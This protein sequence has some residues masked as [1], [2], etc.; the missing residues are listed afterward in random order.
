MSEKDV[1]GLQRAGKLE[2]F[3][4]SFLTIVILLSPLIV[5]PLGLSAVLFA[6][7]MHVILLSAMYLELRTKND[8]LRTLGIITQQFTMLI[9]TF[10]DGQGLA[11][12]Y[13]LFGV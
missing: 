11:K 5:V 6:L 8:E 13:V 7:L 2:L 10:L 12:T 9:L 3:L 4:A 1:E